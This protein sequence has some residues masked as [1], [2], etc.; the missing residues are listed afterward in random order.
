[1]PC[2]NAARDLPGLQLPNVREQPIADIGS[3]ARPSTPT[4][5]RDWMQE[6]C[7]R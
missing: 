5:A 4:V 2:H 7:R 1:M 3:A 6:P